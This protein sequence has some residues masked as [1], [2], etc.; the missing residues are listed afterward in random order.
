[1]STARPPSWIEPWKIVDRGGLRVALVGLLTPDTPE[2]THPDAA[3]FE[4]E[5]P[6]EC[7]A[8][9]ERELAGRCDVVIPVGHLGVDESAELARARPELA[10]IVSGH[11]HTRL[12]R[13]RREGGAL[14]V[15]AGAHAAA[16]GRVELVYDLRERRVTSVEARLIDLAQAPLESD[17]D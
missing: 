17:R 13:G 1:R 5:A 15:Q 2:I 14:I 3:R 4:F 6:S 12:E 10:L 16:L 8:R 9:A 11:S 7:L